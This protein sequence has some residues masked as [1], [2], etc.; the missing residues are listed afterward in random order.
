[1]QRTFYQ[2]LLIW[3]TQKVMSPVTN[4]PATIELPSNIRKIYPIKPNITLETPVHRIGCFLD[5]QFPTHLRPVSVLLSSTTRTTRRCPA[6]MLAKTIAT[7]RF[8]NHT[9]AVA[10]PM[11][12]AY[13]IFNVSGRLRHGSSYTAP[14]LSSIRQ[15][16]RNVSASLIH[17]FKKEKKTT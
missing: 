8:I 10:H 7:R 9:V 12:Q 17:D 11:P 5:I 14:N 2:N 4:F 13:H 15:Q 16:I 1:M 6:A 3:K